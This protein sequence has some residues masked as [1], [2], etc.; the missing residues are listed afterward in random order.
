MGN[1]CLRGK[2]RAADNA[3]FQARIEYPVPTPRIWCQKNPK[4]LATRPRDTLQD[5][6]IAAVA[7]SWNS[8]PSSSLE[9]LPADLVQRVF[10]E[11]VAT[12][13]FALNDLSRFKEL[14]LDTVVLVGRADVKN[15]R[16]RSLDRCFRLRSLDLSGCSQVG[17]CGVAALRRHCGMRHLKLNQCV[18]ITD[19]ALQQLKGLTCLL[20]LE[21]RECELIT[22]E[23]LMHLGGLTQ[24]RHLDLDQC[25]R[26]K[27]GLQH[28]TGLR[29]LVSLRLGWCSFLTDL[30]VAWLR[31]L[32]ALK[33]LRLAYTQVGDEG[34]AHLVTLTC[35]THLDLGGCTSLTDAAASSIQQLTALQVLSLHNCVQFGNAGLAVLV[36][37]P[38]PSLASLTLSYTAVTTTG[39][40]SLSALSSLTQLSLDSCSVGDAACRVLRRLPCLASLD[41]SETLVGDGGLDALTVPLT[42]QQQQGL[43]LPPP[44]PAPPTPPNTNHRTINQGGRHNPHNQ[45]PIP[46][47]TASDAAAAAADS[48]STAVSATRTSPFS[49]VSTGVLVP[50]TGCARSSS[51][52]GVGAA[53][54]G[55]APGPPTSLTHLKL[56][57][58]KV[59]DEGLSKLSLL[60]GLQHLDLD[61]GA[62]RGVDATRGRE[63]GRVPDDGIRYQSQEP[64]DVKK[65]VK[66]ERSMSA[67]WVS[68]VIPRGTSRQLVVC[69]PPLNH[70]SRRQGG[71]SPHS[72]RSAVIVCCALTGATFRSIPITIFDPFARRSSGT[73]P[74]PSSICLAYPP[75]PTANHQPLAVPQRYHH[76]RGLAPR[77][78]FVRIDGSRPVQLPDQ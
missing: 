8:L 47:A 48:S 70:I 3:E 39:L 30:E 74:L 62:R 23:G 57:Y 49:S 53:A 60:V 4:D 24:L 26:I 41:L 44:P 22:G 68:G 50:G 32:N 35:L 45:E 10:D 25:R 38:L 9:A 18:A 65:D 72:A 51:G 33:E 21:L 11:L 13:R 61:S 46:A 7:S 12:G 19:A 77:D 56:T 64:T 55:L 40:S 76:R 66:K 69:Q 29:N 43:Q 27:G 17:D 6:C 15:E 2:K 71:A 54:A 34:L 36:A 37:A 52:S 58:T 28:L 63:G 42:G 16:L 75:N 20:E 14:D 31:C 1:I 59:T 78:G 67:V 5:L 73:A